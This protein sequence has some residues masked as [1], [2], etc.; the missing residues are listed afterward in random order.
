M[1]VGALFYVKIFILNNTNQLTGLS[2]F[3]L[4]GLIY[5]ITAGIILFTLAY[6]RL[7]GL[8][9]LLERIPLISKYRFFIE[10]LEDFHW[11]EL[12]RILSLSFGRYFVFLVQYTLLLDVFNVSV[13]WLDA[14]ALVGVLF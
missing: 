8:I 1:G 12:I 9:E 6:F 13:Y 3:W 7:S 14:F 10:K 4:D 5:V 11:R 2:V